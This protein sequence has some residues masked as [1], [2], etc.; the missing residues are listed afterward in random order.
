MPRKTSPTWSPS[1]NRHIADTLEKLRTAL[2]TVLLPGCL[3]VEKAAY[4]LCCQPNEV[5]LLQKAGLIEFLGDP[6]HKAVKYV[7]TST[8]LE[9]VADP[10]WMSKAR[11]VLYD[12][13]RG[14]AARDRSKKRRSGA[15][16]F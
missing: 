10:S 2:T 13:N 16:P 14:R 15:A 1:T 7:H 9:R 11:S 12:H 5:L 4:F 8:L 6:G 3:P